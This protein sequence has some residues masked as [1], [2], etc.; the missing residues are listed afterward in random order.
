[1]EQTWTKHSKPI[2]A[3]CFNYDG[4]VLKVH[5]TSLHYPFFNNNGILMCTF[6]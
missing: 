6:E 3:V 1:M 4:Y 5:C 2:R